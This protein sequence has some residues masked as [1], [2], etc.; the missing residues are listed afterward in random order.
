MFKDLYK[1]DLIPPETI[2]MTHREAL[3]QYM[4]GKIIFYQGGSNF[5]NMI[6]ENAPSPC[7]TK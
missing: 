4:A 1:K 7:W 3:E 2:T 6:R 5:L